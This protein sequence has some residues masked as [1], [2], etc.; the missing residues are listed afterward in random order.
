MLEWKAMFDPF[1][2]IDQDTVSEF[3]LLSSCLLKSLLLKG[4][5]HVF[6]LGYTFLK[7]KK[8]TID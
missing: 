1:C 8:D 2:D 6:L 4:L 5:K 3:M 7:K